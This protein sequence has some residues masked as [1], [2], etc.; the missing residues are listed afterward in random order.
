MDNSL[1]MMMTG[2][3]DSRDYHR[4]IANFL[5][6]SSLTSSAVTIFTAP[7]C[8][9]V[10]SHDTVPL[11]IKIALKQEVENV[12]MATGSKIALCKAA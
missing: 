8:L 11:I 5:I 2:P 6:T 10:T 1:P 3:L 12:K 4:S 7:V 9:F